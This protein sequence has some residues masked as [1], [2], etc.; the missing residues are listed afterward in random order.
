MHTAD[1]QSLPVTAGDSLARYSTRQS[2]ALDM[3]FVKTPNR[4]QQGLLVAQIQCEELL[5]A[6]IQ[7]CQTCN[8]PALLT[9]ISMPKLSHTLT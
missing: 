4:Q 9:S 7:C 1:V 8:A 3:L 5:V 2:L 6:Q